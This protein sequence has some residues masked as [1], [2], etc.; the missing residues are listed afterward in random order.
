MGRGPCTQGVYLKEV[1]LPPLDW[2]IQR[3][4]GSGYY[5]YK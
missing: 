5:P 1:P 3:W 2:D 4:C